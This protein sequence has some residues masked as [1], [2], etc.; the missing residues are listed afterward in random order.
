[1]NIDSFQGGF[2]GPKPSVMPDPF[3]MQTSF[4]MPQASQQPTMNIDSFQG[5]FE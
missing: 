3:G 4:Q 1:M 2:E 5:G